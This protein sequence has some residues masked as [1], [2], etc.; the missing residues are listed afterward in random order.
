[1]AAL[2]PATVTLNG[3]RRTASACGRRALTRTDGMNSDPTAAR[4][5]DLPRF[6]AK[7][8]LTFDKLGMVAQNR[9]SE[10]R[11]D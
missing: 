8:G 4:S 7:A 9:S 6:E 10:E 1:M 11:G 3:L 2:A 5:V